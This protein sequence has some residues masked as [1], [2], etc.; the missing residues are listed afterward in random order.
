[1]FAY[2]HE[3][4]NILLSALSIFS[5]LLYD[6]NLNTQ[7]FVYLEFVQCQLGLVRNVQI[8]RNAIYAYLLNTCFIYIHV[9]A[10]SLSK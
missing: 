1:M 9:K 10:F 5:F 4:I 7:G 3:K 6:F 8:S 2:E